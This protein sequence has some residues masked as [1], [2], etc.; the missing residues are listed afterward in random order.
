FFGTGGPDGPAVASRPVWGEFVA[1]GAFVAAALPVAFA[2]TLAGRAGPRLRT[3]VWVALL[4]V[5][6]VIPTA[7]F[8]RVR[9]QERIYPRSALTDELTA[10]APAGEARV[11][12]WHVPGVLNDQTSALGVGAPMALV[13]RLESPA[14]Y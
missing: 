13:H 10:R 1:H 9:E 2:L 11:S 4:V 14:G 8:V 5:E 6:T 3:G 7:R 12:D